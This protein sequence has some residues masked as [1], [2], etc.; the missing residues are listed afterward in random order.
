VG[1]GHDGVTRPRRGD[2]IGEGRSHDFSDAT[3][4]K[5]GGLRQSQSCCPTTFGIQ[6]FLQLAIMGA[7]FDQTLR[8]WAALW[9]QVVV[10]W[11]LAWLILRHRDRSVK[12]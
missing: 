6:G 2:Q 3:D 5:Q 7:R 10:Y 9:I 12:L 8:P 4:S 11:C 1:C